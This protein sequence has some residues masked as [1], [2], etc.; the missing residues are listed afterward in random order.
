MQHDRS[1]EPGDRRTAA[2]NRAVPQVLR[3]HV[4]IDMKGYGR[5]L[6]ERPNA[7]TARIMRTFVRVVRAALPREEV[8]VEQVADTFSLVFSDALEAVRTTEA[9]AGSLT[10]HAAA[11]RVL[12]AGIGIDVGQSLRSKGRYVGVALV[13]ASALSHRARPGQILITQNVLTLVR[14]ELVTQP[15]DIGPL[16]FAEGRVHLYELR[17][18]DESSID[19]DGRSLVALLFFDMVGSTAK[20]A[21]VGA[22]AWK[23]TV[24]RHHA[25]ARAALRRFRGVEIDTAGDG[26]YAT[27]RM[28]SHAIECALA[29]RDGLRS[30]LSLDIR[31]GVH[32]A[33]CEIIAGKV[34][35]I[36]VAVAS[37]VMNH[38]GAGD[39]LVS[40]AVKDTLLGGRF[41]FREHGTVALKGVPGD[42]VLYSVE[43]R[44]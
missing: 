14:N 23:D 10:R 8:E 3:T 16:S 25:I 43:K 18:P 19:D 6:A 30:E 26:F 38:G 1:P 9:I 7:E 32:A 39:V 12:S 24:E 21:A 31:A 37:R 11:G 44:S 27:F 33:E 15:R 41:T 5:L 42:W 40:Q 17:P 20:A 36:G 4:F 29:I 28:P 2:H 34:G 35:G 22:A 13:N